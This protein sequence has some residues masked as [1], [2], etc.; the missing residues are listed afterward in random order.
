MIKLSDSQPIASGT[1]RAVYAY[2]GHQD[3]LIKVLHSMEKELNHDGLKGT[4][5][6]KFPNTI[7][8]FLFR[9]YDSYIRMMMALGSS[10][11]SP[12]MAHQW[13][14]VETDLGLGMICERI[15][16]N[17]S[18]I[19]PTTKQILQN[20][21]ISEHLDLL[22]QFVQN[23]FTFDVRLNDLNARNVVLGERDGRKQFILI[24]G[25]GDSWVIPLRRWSDRINNKSLQR[26]IAILAHEL[27]LSWDEETGSLRQYG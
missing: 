14:L 21:D 15:T 6:R 1:R 26:R 2:P 5:R 9:E 4:I 24:D 22:N 17:N 10:D 16:L 13:G 3:R 23:L 18:D 19:A 8:R 12:P 25:M 20:G 7:Y 11:V 27:N